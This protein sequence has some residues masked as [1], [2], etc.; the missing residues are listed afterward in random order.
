MCAVYQLILKSD[1]EILKKLKERYGTE[2]CEKYADTRLFPKS[3][4]PALGA[5]RK[6]ALLKWGFPVKGKSRTVFNARAESLSQRPMFKS[7]VNNRCIIPASS[8]FE[9]GE[10]NGKKHKFVIRTNDDI[11]FFAAIFKGFK[12]KTGNKF[13]FYTIITTEPNEQ[14]RNIHM[15]M[16]V[17]LD[18]DGQEKWLDKNLDPSG[19]LIPYEGKL[20]I[21]KADDDK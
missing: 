21:D 3:E 20:S 12:D 14:I 9:W 4:A 10:E 17:I 8:F 1:S 6:I 15:R 2:I 19:I 18:K 5:K 16:P 13:F 7:C 11:M